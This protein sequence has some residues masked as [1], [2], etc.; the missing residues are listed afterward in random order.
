[1][2][3]ITPSLLA[4]ATLMLSGVCAQAA[5]HPVGVALQAPTQLA[6]P[7]LT[8]PI[9]NGV[10]ITAIT[11]G[12]SDFTPCYNCAGVGSVAVPYLLRA[13]PN[14][15][16]IISTV[17][18]Q[19]TIYTGYPTVNYSLVQNGQTLSSSSVTFPFLVYPGTEDLAYFPDTASGASGYAE[20]KIQVMDGSTELTHD[21]YVIYIR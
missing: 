11:V 20:V 19:P 17:Q 18:F 15:T 4:M 9:G 8:G 14:G 21:A 5:N 10:V 13:V 7:N 6:A 2:K 16:S 1:M 3:K 12:S